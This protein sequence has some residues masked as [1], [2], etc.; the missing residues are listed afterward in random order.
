MK[1]LII[2]MVLIMFLFAGCIQIEITDESDEFYSRSRVD[3]ICAS[4]S[5]GKGRTDDIYVALKY[6]YDSDELSK[7]YGDS[8]EM[9]DNNV[10]CYTSEGSGFIGIYKG[11]AR[12]GFVLDSTT[13]IVS[14]SKKY[15]GKWEVND[16]YLENESD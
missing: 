8:F 15:F 12:Y 6:I 14:L 3:S 10:I 11:E 4:E 2:G 7:L 1:K 16:F 13:Y 5:F 9:S